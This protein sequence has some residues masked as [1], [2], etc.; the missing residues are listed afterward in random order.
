MQFEVVVVDNDSVDRTASI[1]AASGANVVKEPVRN[2]GRARNRGAASCRGE[3][4]VFIDADTLVP[5]QLFRRIA[6]LLDDPQC[7]GGAADALHDS[8]RRFIRLYLRFWRFV[9]TAAGLAQGAVQF[10]TRDAFESV[11]GYDES[12]WMGEDVDFYRRL[13]KFAKR[14]QRHV[15][16]M[17]DVCVYPSPRRFNR[18]S[19]WEILLRTNPLFILLFQRR[20]SA[21]KGWYDQLIR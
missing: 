16:F 14:N 15:Q 6:G 4:L 21:W 9:G 8:N 1:A 2:I 5:E 3:W 7:V 11:R 18:W 19:V 12:L 13:E 20:R 17:R 10:C